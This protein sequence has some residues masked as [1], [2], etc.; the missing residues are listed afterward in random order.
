MAPALQAKAQEEG[1]VLGTVLREGAS[2]TMLLR[3]KGVLNITSGTCTGGRVGGA[4]AGKGGLCNN[5]SKT[6]SLY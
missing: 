2:V 4:C 5:F 1:R 3:S 6:K